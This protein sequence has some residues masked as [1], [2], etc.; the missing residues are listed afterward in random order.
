MMKK[1][2][3]EEKGSHTNDSDVDEEETEPLLK[4]VRM[5]NDVVNILQKD[6]A[7][8][9][10]AHP[11][12]LCLG[13]HWGTIHILDHQ[14]SCSNDGR[15]FIY[16]LYSTEN[17][18]NISTGHWVKSIAIDPL[19]YKSGS[20]RKFIIG[21][22]QLV[23]YEK[24]FLSRIKST[25]LWE[26]EGSVRAIAWAGHFIAWASDTGVRVYDLNDRSSLG[27]IKWTE[28]S[29]TVP[30]QYRCNLMWSNDRTLLIGWVDT[31]RICRIKKCFNHESGNRDL[32]SF[33]IEPV[34]T[35]RVDFYISGI[36][37]LDNQL[38]LLGCYKE[39]SKDGK[40]QRPTLYIIEPKYQDFNIVCENSLSLRG[41]E[42]YSCND[43]HLDCLIEEN[44]NPISTGYSTKLQPLYTEPLVIVGVEPS[45]TY[46]LKKLNEAG[47]RGFE[48]TASVSQL[49][50]WTGYNDD[51]SYRRQEER[52]T[53]KKQTNELQA[54]ILQ[55]QAAQQGPQVPADLTLALQGIG[56]VMQR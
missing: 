35:F 46:R 17:N 45:D 43:Y 2:Q 40:R 31:V 53:F 20:G 25:V 48:T 49:K 16:G 33:V 44:R 54:Q 32:S 14:A 18:H 30:D 56:I 24:T 39:L 11:K 38:I 27:L 1:S 10:V 52:E 19:Y 50:V 26:A 41:Y 29:E 3:V 22:D 36:A 21:K 34:S 5:R 6:A 28:S 51:V 23:M 12:F 13:S 15:V 55:L 4:Y 47:D 9:I 7:S 42:E 37:P 8:C